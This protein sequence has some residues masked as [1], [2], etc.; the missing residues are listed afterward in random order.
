MKH[1]P[2]PTR[3][4]SAA[5]SAGPNT[6]DPVITAVLSERTLGMSSVD[7]FGDQ[8][9]PGGVVDGGQHA[10]HDRQAVHEAEG[11][12]T[13]QVEDAEEKPGLAGHA[14]LR[15]DG[16]AAAVHFGRRARRPTVRGAGGARIGRPDA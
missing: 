16:E 9:A 3:A 2:V 15:H 13:G 11:D 8:A 1:Q 14:R 6:R 7:E 4:T 10:E 12:D 5:A